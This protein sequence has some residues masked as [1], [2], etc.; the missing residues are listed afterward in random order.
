M[1]DQHREQEQHKKQ[2]MR[3]QT[4]WRQSRSSLRRQSIR[5]LP[6]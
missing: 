5:N 4:P 6:L 2:I 3:A 1:P